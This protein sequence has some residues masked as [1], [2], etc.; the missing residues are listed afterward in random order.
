MKLG[1][2]A[3]PVLAVALAPSA[4]ACSLA[5]TPQPP[6]REEGESYAS[7]QARIAE[8][9]LNQFREAEMEAASEKA[10]RVGYEQ[11]LWEAANVVALVEVVAQVEP[12]EEVDFNFKPGVCLK[13]V[14]AERG[15]PQ[16]EPFKITIRGH[17][18]CGPYGHLRIADSEIGERFV[19]FAK[20]NALSM[21][22]VIIGYAK[23][24]AEIYRTIQLFEK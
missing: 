6:D 17:S 13:V 7:H 3:L 9:H 5:P 16:S 15:S 14:H 8:F 24:E 23:D 12:P 10:E 19:V 18:S 21:A 4:Q 20:Y 1:L 2:F 11:A 22:S